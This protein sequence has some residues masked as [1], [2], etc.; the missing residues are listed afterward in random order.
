MFLIQKRSPF[1]NKSALLLECNS[2]SNSNSNSNLSQ[3]IQ[4]ATEN[5]QVNSKKRKHS[6]SSRYYNWDDYDGFRTS[7]ANRMRHERKQSRKGRRRN[8]IPNSPSNGI[9]KNSDSSDDD[10]EVMMMNYAGKQRLMIDWLVKNR[11]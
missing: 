2:N 7:K 8:W 6:R 3:S 5:K 9:A 11:Y 10:E 1:P 4:V